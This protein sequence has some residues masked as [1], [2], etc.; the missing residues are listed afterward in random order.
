MKTKAKAAIQ[1]EVKAVWDGEFFDPFEIEVRYNGN[2]DID[3]TVATSKIFV[4]VL[5][6]LGIVTQDSTQHYRKLTVKFDPSIENFS[7]VFKIKEYDN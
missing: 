3:N 5:R 6:S 7:Y 2:F 4:D 1:R